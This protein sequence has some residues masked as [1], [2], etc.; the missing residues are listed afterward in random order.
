M[1]F[2]VNLRKDGKFILVTF[3]DIP[4]AITQG[5]DRAHALEMAKE[6]LES[7]M[8]FYFEDRR[9]VPAPSAPK[10]GQAVVQLPPSVAAK[11]LLLNEMLRQNVR[12]VELARRIGT[13][14][15]EVNRL[16]DLR[17][18]TKIDRID[19]ALRALGKRLV[20]EAA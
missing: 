5:N 12:P 13:T 19:A 14:K 16:T 18:A 7:A 8:D 10:R 11:V 6:A 17:H 1:E 2:P 9:P 3:P 4:E 15:Q 20:V